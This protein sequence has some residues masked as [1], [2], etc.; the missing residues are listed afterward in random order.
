MRKHR[1][2]F[3]A[4]SSRWAGIW[5]LVL[6]GLGAAGCESKTAC[7]PC[8]P[9]SYPSDPSE[10]CSECRACPDLVTDASPSNVTIWCRNGAGRHD[11]SVGEAG[12]AEAAALDSTDE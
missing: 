12:G 7:T 6:S 4:W 1:Y 5:V 3:R 2:R 10:D 8:G 11:A 9:G